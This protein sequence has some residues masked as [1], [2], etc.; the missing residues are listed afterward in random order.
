MFGDKV[1]YAKHNTTEDNKWCGDNDPYEKKNQQSYDDDVE[2]VQ[3]YD[4]F[5][6]ENPLLLKTHGRIFALPYDTSVCYDRDASRY[7]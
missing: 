5:D 7:L 4:A 2:H 6:H 3:R 1:G